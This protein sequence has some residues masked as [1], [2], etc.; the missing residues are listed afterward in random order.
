MSRFS[1]VLISAQLVAALVLSVLAQVWLL[2]SEIRA[3]VAMYPEVQPLVIPGIIWGIAAIACLQGIGIVGLRIVVLLRTADA[4]T[5]P[6]A[7]SLYKARVYRWLWAVV[8]C[9]VAFLALVIVAYTALAVL[10]YST[11]AMLALIAARIVATAA[12]IALAL[13]LTTRPGIRTDRRSGQR[14]GYPLDDQLDDRLDDRRV[15]AAHHPA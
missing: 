13:F 15:D 9:L 7:A 5:S 14:L 6:T 1:S 12:A 10:G 2:P 11:P 8:G 3:T 4:S